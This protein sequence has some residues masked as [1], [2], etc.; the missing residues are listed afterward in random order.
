MMGNLGFVESPKDFDG[1]YKGLTLPPAQ[2]NYIWTL[3]WLSLGSGILVPLGVWL[4]S[5]NYW[6]HPDFSWRRFVDII[7]VHMSLAYQISRAVRAQYAISYFCVLSVG[8][9]F[10]LIG[11]YFH[12]KQPWLSTLCH[13]M[14]HILGNV[15]NVILYSGNISCLVWC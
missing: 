3:S 10:F 12:K 14:S 5:I 7:Y 2:A 9:F 15:S 8:V 4:T 6:R 11:L 13:G 1:L